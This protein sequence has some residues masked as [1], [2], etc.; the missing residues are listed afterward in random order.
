MRPHVPG[1]ATRRAC[2]RVVAHLTL[3]LVAFALGRVSKRVSIVYLPDGWLPATRGDPRVYE[4]AS[5]TEAAPGPGEGGEFRFEDARGAYERREFLLDDDG[6]RRGGGGAHASGANANAMTVVGGRRKK[7]SFWVNLV[8]TRAG[9][10]RSGDIHK[11]AQL[12]VIIAGRARLTTIPDVRAGE[13]VVRELAAGDRVVIPPHVPH[14]YDFLDDTLMTEAWLDDDKTQ[15]EF[16]AWLYEPLRK[17]I[18][19][20]TLLE[21]VDAGGGGRARRGLG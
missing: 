21:R 19:K 9:H 4:L 18:P 12:N 15:C 5:A 2:R 7:R 13:E 17:R 16:K 10:L 8:F 14:L 6:V 1:T 11:C 20:E 3:L